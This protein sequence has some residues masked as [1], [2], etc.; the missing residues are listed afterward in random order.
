MEGG[1]A[2]DLAARVINFVRR[3]TSPEFRYKVKRALRRVDNPEV[4]NARRL[5]KRMRTDPADVLY[6]GDSLAS[7]VGLDDTDPRPLHQMVAD[8]LAGTATVYTV[9]DGGYGPELYESFLRL[10]EATSA[11]PLILHDI[12]PRILHPL[13][14]HPTYGKQAAIPV[15]HRLDPNGATWR[16][17]ASIP[18]ATS[19]D[20]ER[21]YALPHP[22]ILGDNLTVG[23]YVKPLKNG[24]GDPEERL[25]ILYAYHHGAKLEPTTPSLQAYVILGHRIRTMGCPTVTF[26]GP[27][28]IPTGIELFGPEFEGLMD[29]N[30]KVMEDLYREAL[31]RDATILESGTIFPPEDFIDVTDGTEHLNDRGRQRLTKMIAEAIRQELGR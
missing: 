9:A 12:G 4:R 1:K 14:A 17:R 20:F 29:K 2:N 3:R 16:M 19:E 7:A 8:E 23:D 6:L 15:I 11:R 26:R 21:Y 30:W 5:V 22:T 13:I 18:R 27:V 31:G 10:V 24:A 25:R 28:S